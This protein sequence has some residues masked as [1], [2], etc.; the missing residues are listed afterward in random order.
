[1]HE[2]WDAC[3]LGCFEDW[4]FPKTLPF[5]PTLKVTYETTST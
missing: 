1:M 4:H 3:A 5:F 2:P